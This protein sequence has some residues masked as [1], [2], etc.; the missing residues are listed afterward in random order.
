MIYA[1][2]VFQID[3]N[4]LS[5]YGNDV[6]FELVIAYKKISKGILVPSIKNNPS[7]ND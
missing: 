5:N 1:N 3:H 6:Q 7:K 4:W 2:D